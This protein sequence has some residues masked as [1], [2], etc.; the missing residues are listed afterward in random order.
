MLRAFAATRQPHL[1]RL[2][3]GK[4][5]GSGQHS[6]CFFAGVQCFGLNASHHVPLSGPFSGNEGAQHTIKI[7]LWLCRRKTR[8]GKKRA[9]GFRLADA[10]FDNEHTVRCKQRRRARCNRAVTIESVETAVEPPWPAGGR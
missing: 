2:R 1:G 8:G 6:K 3:A 7:G 9:D 4:L 5:M 10:E